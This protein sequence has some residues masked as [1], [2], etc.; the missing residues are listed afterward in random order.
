MNKVIIVDSNIPVEIDRIIQFSANKLFSDC[1]T[2]EEVNAMISAYCSVFKTT[3]KIKDLHVIRFPLPKSE[4]MVACSILV[5]DYSGARRPERD[6]Y[7]MDILW[8]QKDYLFPI[9]PFILEE[10]R[11][12]PFRKIARKSEFPF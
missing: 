2:Q 6:I 12:L 3:F 10:L 9:D 7:D 11:R 4:K 5:S 8:F 1:Q